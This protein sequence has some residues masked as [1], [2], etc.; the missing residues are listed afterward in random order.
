MQLDRSD[1]EFNSWLAGFIDAEGCFLIGK[2]KSS[3]G[4]FRCHVRFSLE[5]REDDAE[6]LFEVQEKTG[7]GNVV[8]L[9]SYR[10]A[11]P[12][13][14]WM[15]TSK[16]DRIKL[17]NLLNKFPLRS[18]KKYDFDF[19]SKAHDLSMKVK[20]G[21]VSNSSIWEEIDELKNEME[22]NRRFSPYE[23]SG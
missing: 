16:A 15:I 1:I 14:R 23:L 18:K 11:N 8:L 2:Q 6:I 13:V 19:W 21:P 17:I 12:T 5:L 7:I 22:S 4:S 20:S 9:N 10:D 3:N